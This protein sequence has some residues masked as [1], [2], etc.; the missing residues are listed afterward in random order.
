MLFYTGYDSKA[1]SEEWFNHPGL[2]ESSAGYLAELG[3]NAVGI[4]AP[5]IDHEPFPG[6]RILLPRGDRDL[7]EPGQPEAV[8]REAPIP[9]LRRTPKDLGWVG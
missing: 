5:S 9:I 3:V 1:G 8:D 2:E 6:H 4:D 7:R